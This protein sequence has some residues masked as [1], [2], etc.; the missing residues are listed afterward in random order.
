[1]EQST[2]AERFKHSK[3]DRAHNCRVKIAII[4]LKHYNQNAIVIP[5]NKLYHSYH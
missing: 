3:I 2:Y 5:S 1:M 4:H